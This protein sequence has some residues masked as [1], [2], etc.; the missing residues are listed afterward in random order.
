MLNFSITIQ[1]PDL[2]RHEIEI[3]CP[4]CKLSNWVKIGEIRRRD[5]VVCR[6]CHA[7]LLLEDHLGQVQRFTQEFEH[8]FKEL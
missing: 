3:D 7:N 2:D 6:G 8:L 1:L 4:I 5:Y